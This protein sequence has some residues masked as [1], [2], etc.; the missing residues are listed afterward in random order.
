MSNDNNTQPNIQEQL[1]QI[2][3]RLGDLSDL[4]R[5][6]SEMLRKRGMDLPPTAQEN[7]RSLRTKMDSVNRLVGS[8]FMELQSLRGLAQ[9]AAL[10][11]SSLDTT[12]VLNQVM[13]TAIN[14]T[15]AE[16]GYI[17]L[18]NQETGEL[19]DF[20]V[21]RGMDQEALGSRSDDPSTGKTYIISSTVVNRVAETGE[22]VLTDNA[23]EDPLFENQKSVVGHALRSILA[24]PLKARGNLLGVVYCD[25]RIVHALFGENERDLLTAF[26]DQAAVA[27]ENAR[28]FEAARER[29]SQITEM[30]DLINNIFNSIVITIDLEGRIITCNAASREI[31]N[32]QKAVDL[33]IQEVFPK[34]PDDFYELLNKVF[35]T[36][37]QQLVELQPNVEGLGERYWNVI[38]SPLRDI[39]GVAHGIVFVLDD[40][41]EQKKHETRMG[42]LMKYMLHSA[43]LEGGMDVDLS[44]EER[45][46]SM[47]ATDVR[48]FTSFSEKL[49][50]E[51]LMQIINKYLSVA[52]DGINL[53][54]GIVDKYMGDDVTGLFNTQMNPQEDHAV[55]AVNAAWSI[56]YDLKYGLHD[57][58][59]EN[60]QL[61]FGIGVH[62]GPA[63]LGNVGGADRQEFSA[64][65][66]AQS[67]SKVLESNADKGE[68]LVSPQTYELT[69]DFFEYEQVVPENT[70]GF[71][72]PVAYKVLNRKKNKATGALFLDPE[73]ADML[74]DI[75]SLTD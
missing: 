19:D 57:E 8:S 48:G 71:D 65:G 54:E 15:G 56:M 23:T 42:E 55:R 68:I 28:L 75:G 63:F 67:I 41:T 6:Q 16:R 58:L 26:A 46:I 18:I 37:E 21:A 2:K 66:E 17:V 50:P 9:N 60:Q 29:L 53:Y 3:S 25:N 4:L 74:D 61:Y 36:G 49:E 43:L 45:I 59:P 52:S 32:V 14:L 35:E 44:G 33:P 70:K 11:N 72:I 30:R 73:L 64:M 22:P 51:E 40:V 47:I 24:V 34:V 69:K 31:L 5:N 20:R 39:K 1:K 7:L 13:D 10:I 38:I 62:T 27:L 12:T